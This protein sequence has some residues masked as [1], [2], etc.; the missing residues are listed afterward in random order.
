MKPFR[1]FAWQFSQA[2]LLTGRNVAN[3]S[4]V[5]AIEFAIIAPILLL[6]YIGN[7]EL[8][9]ALTCDQKLKHATSVVGDLI[10]QSSTLTSDDV[11]QI[12]TAANAVLQPYSPN[13]LKL[14]VSV[15]S[16]KPDG[17]SKVSWSVGQ[18]MDRR[19]PGSIYQTPPNLWTDEQKSLVVTET[20]YDYEPVT[21]D[22]FE[23]SIEL[24]KVTY[25][26]PRGM[27]TITCTDC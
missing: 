19:S 11:L 7:I 21:S 23:K 12:F 13:P 8:T 15:L 10:S 5:A 14:R 22:I 20:L 2:P 9:L 3:R 26:R 16:P 6:I 18:N 27:W 25:S 1:R 24:S 17:Q 4:G